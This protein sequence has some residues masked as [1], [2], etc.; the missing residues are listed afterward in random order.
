MTKTRLLALLLLACGATTGACGESTTG[1]RVVLQ[2]EASTDMLADHTFVSNLGWTVT[3]TRGEIT[4]GAFYYFEGPPPVIEMADAGNRRRGWFRKAL[5]W[6]SPIGTAHA[7]PGHYA[8]G[9][10]MGQM[11]ESGAIDLMAS[12]TTALPD[13]EGITGLYR[14]GTFSFSDPGSGTVATVEGVAVKGDQT[15]NFRVAGSMADVLANAKDARIAGSTFAETTVTGDGKVTATVHPAI[16]FTLV[17][18]NGLPAGTP[19]APTDLAPGTVPHIA[20]ALG[21]AQ[22]AAYTFE[23]TEGQAP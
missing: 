4:T 1:K 9:R 14:S 17:D 21:L 12:G 3:L 22:I 11:L 10:A 19:E 23:F 5:D 2:T 13:G 18:F 8:P 7:H 6:L 15:V 20:F 16:W